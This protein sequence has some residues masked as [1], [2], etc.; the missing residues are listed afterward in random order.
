M[1]AFFGKKKLINRNFRL[2]Y[3]IELI[4]DNKRRVLN[5]ILQP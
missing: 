5:V 2:A 3:S 1:A 4:F